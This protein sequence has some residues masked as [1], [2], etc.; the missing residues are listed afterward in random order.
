MVSTFTMTIDDQEIVC[1]AFTLDEYQEF[2]ISRDNGTLKETI[3]NLLAACCP[4]AHTLNKHQSELVI[5]NLWAH[6]IAQEHILDYTCSC[7]KTQ[8]VK[9]NFGHTQLT[10]HELQPY[11]LGNAKLHLRYP[12][13]FEEQD[14]FDMVSQCIERIQV[15]AE[16]LSIEELSEEEMSQLVGAITDTVVVE[17]AEHLLEPKPV[18]GVPVQC[19]C[20]EHNV[21]VISGLKEFFKLF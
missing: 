2:M 3:F 1:R 18:L 12:M 19:E 8:K 17:I 10:E 14:K 9:V 7:G 5:V 13:L 6:S 15:G 16:N 4:K 11:Q 20:G 21:H